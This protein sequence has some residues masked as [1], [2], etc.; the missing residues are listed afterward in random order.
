MIYIDLN[1]MH[2]KSTLFFAYVQD[3]C[4]FLAKIIVPVCRIRNFLL[5]LQRETENIH[6]YDAL[7]SLRRSGGRVEM[8]LH[9]SA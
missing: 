3:F 7:L 1:D 6:T 2:C 8:G 9:G 5:I 4:S